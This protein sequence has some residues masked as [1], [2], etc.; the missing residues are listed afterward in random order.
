MAALREWRRQLV[1]H[2]TAAGHPHVLT[3][4]QFAILCEINADTLDAVPDAATQSIVVDVPAL[5]LLRQRLALRDPTGAL[6]AAM[7]ATFGG[8]GSKYFSFA[9]TKQRL[10]AAILHKTPALANA[11]VVLVLPTAVNSAAFMATCYGF[12]HGARAFRAAIDMVHKGSVPDALALAQRLLLVRPGVRVA[13]VLL[14][15]S[16]YERSDFGTLEALAGAALPNVALY[17]IVGTAMPAAMLPRRKNVHKAGIVMPAQP[18]FSQRLG[19]GVVLPAGALGAQFVPLSGVDQGQ[20]ALFEHT[21]PPPA[22]TPPVMRTPMAYDATGVHIVAMPSVL[23]VGT[24]PDPGPSSFFG[25][26]TWRSEKQEEP[27]A[28]KRARSATP[29]E[30]EESPNPNDTT[31]S[32]PAENSDILDVND[33]SQWVL[34]PDD[35]DPFFVDDAPRTE[36]EDDPFDIF[37][38]RQ[39]GTCVVHPGQRARR[40][41]DGC[42]LALYCTDACQ[43]HHWSQSGH[44]RVCGLPF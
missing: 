6:D 18:V 3:P 2:V 39:L 30:E 8:T 27:R 43:A 44:A 7:L 24:A 22:M 9:E 40:V 34:P 36:P 28:V 15:F 5:T 20:L 17:I 10:L 19:V 13:F 23:R 32:P 42:G 38:A 35:N 21:L 14:A 1:A 11:T 26:L 31:L 4:E 29:D 25:T 16:A 33:D 12:H 41:C 37:R